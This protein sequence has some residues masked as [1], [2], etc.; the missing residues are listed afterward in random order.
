MTRE[1]QKLRRRIEQQDDCSNGGNGSSSGGVLSGRSSQSATPHDSLSQGSRA[2]SNTSLNTLEY[3]NSNGSSLHQQVM[4]LS[5][6]TFLYPA[7]FL[8]LK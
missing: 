2:S 5:K 4:Q 1:V 8:K 3:Q 6:L 7:N